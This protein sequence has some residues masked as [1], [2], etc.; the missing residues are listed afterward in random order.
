VQWVALPG[1]VVLVT[2]VEGTVLPANPSRVYL[3]II[4]AGPNLCHLAF[5]GIIAV[6]NSGF[7]LT[8]VNS[9]N[10]LEWTGACMNTGEVRAICAAGT[11]RLCI[12]EGVSP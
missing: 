5:G 7:T 12:Q 3:R 9:G 6:A 11:A 4:D 2:T 10:F 8:N 1:S